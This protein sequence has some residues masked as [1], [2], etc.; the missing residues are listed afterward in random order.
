MSNTQLFELEEEELMKELEKIEKDR[1]EKENRIL[2]HIR[3]G[4]KLFFS[5]QYKYREGLIHPCVEKTY[6]YQFT[7]FDE[8]G[9]IGDF[10]RNSIEEVAK[11]IVEYGFRP[12]E[13]AKKKLLR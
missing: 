12:L 9:P 2:E 13:T 3:S 4:N 5:E 10:R 8:A 7:Y 1:K 6:P 11:G